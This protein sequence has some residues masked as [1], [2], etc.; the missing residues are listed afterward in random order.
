MSPSHSSR[1]SNLFKIGPDSTDCG[2]TYATDEI[3]KIFREGEWGCSISQDPDQRGGLIAKYPEGTEVHQNT[4]SPDFNPATFR[5]SMIEFDPFPV[6][7]GP[8]PFLLICP[9]NDPN[10]SNVMRHVYHADR[11]T[12]RL[13]ASKSGNK[14]T[15]TVKYDQLLGTDDQG[16]SSWHKHE[17]W[18]PT[19]Y[20]DVWD[21]SRETL[22]DGTKVCRMGTLPRS[23]A[24]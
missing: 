21:L 3:K 24:R 10:G 5:G 18:G 14:D 9:T 13:L 17:V 19:G 22:P 20:Y 8:E 12:F 6:R 23:S 4:L 2:S 1:Q 16:E 11:A 15:L 7:S